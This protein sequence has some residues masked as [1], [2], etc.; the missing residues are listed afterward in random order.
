MQNKLFIILP[1]KEFRKYTEKLN[2]QLL[3]QCIWECNVKDM[4]LVDAFEVCDMGF[5]AAMAGC[6]CSSKVTVRVPEAG[7]SSVTGLR[8]WLPLGSR[9][10]HVTAHGIDSAAKR[11]P[12]DR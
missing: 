6:G 4:F 8:S 11:L 5:P 2:T 9:I 3:L 10:V 7:S 12:I 1:Q